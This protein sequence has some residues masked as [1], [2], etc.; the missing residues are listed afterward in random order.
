MELIICHRHLLLTKVDIIFLINGNL[1]THCYACYKHRFGYDTFSL[2]TFS[3]HTFTIL[4]IQ[5][6]LENN[7]TDGNASGKHDSVLFLKK[8]HWA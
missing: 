1:E 4:S 6:S 3:A 5:F 8:K 2:I 7:L